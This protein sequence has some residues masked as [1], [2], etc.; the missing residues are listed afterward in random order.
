M[1]AFLEKLAANRKTTL[2]DA[3]RKFGLDVRLNGLGSRDDLRLAHFLRLF[4]IQTVLDVGANRGQFAQELYRSGY[5]GK[6][7][8]FEALPAAHAQLSAT[9]SQSRQDWSVAPCAAIGDQSGTALFHVTQSD[10]ASSLLEPTAKLVAAHSAARA[11][12]VIPVETRRL[13]DAVREL[14]I[15]TDNCFLKMDVQGAEALVLAGAPCVL[16]AARGLMMELSWNGLYENQP[17]SLAILNTATTAGY[18]VWDVWPGYRDPKTF[19]L[20]QTDVVCFRA[21]ALG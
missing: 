6:I 7:I 13:D 16:A 18:E 2:R 15:A 19:R 14:E 10:T 12:E 4:D 17:S 11:V 5:S 8:S 3:G 9:A 21:G 20:N 1:A